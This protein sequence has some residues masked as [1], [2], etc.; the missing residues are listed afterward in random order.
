MSNLEDLKSSLYRY[1]QDQLQG[2]IQ[3]IQSALA[4]ITESRDNET[5]SSVGDK[6]E[7][8]RAMMQLEEEKYRTQLANVLQSKSIFDRIDPKQAPQK[9]EIG[10]LVQTDQGWY[11][12][13]VAIG[14]ATLHGKTIFIIS[15][16]A[17]VGRLLMHKK[18]GDQIAFQG[19][20]FSILNIS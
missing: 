20:K 10:S 11:Y 7:T 1:C 14:K 19:R 5:K 6:Y 17:P 9:V 3:V 2:K 15:T 4:S 13:A 12:L 16:D 18:A 8:G